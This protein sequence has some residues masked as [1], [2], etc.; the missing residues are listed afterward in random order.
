RFNGDEHGS[1]NVDDWAKIPIWKDQAA[2]VGRLSKSFTGTLGDP[3]VSEAG[4]RFLADL[5]AQLAD[6]QLRDLFDVARVDRGIVGSGRP[7]R[8]R[9][10]AWVEAFKHKRDEIVTNR[11]AQ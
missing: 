6:E 2:C 5:L 1:V 11:C 8:A 10:E 4:R 9:T 7:S 3:H